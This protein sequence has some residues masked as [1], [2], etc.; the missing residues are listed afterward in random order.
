V[1][2]QSESVSRVSP[3]MSSEP[4]SDSDSLPAD[5]S[6][7][8]TQSSSAGSERDGAEARSLPFTPDF[9]A[10]LLAD[11][12]GESAE[13]VESKLIRCQQIIDYHFRDP[14]LLHAAL[15]HASCATHRLASNERL[16]FLGDS[17]LGII[18]C[19]WLYQEYPE[20]SEGDLTK[21]K[22]SVVSRRS[23]GKVACELGLD[24]CLIVGK[25]VMKSRSFP[26][27]L[28]SDVFESVVAAIFLDGGLDMVRPRLRKWLAGEVSAAVE[29]QN[30]GNY[31][32]TLQQYAQRECASTPVYKLISESG[33]DHRKRFQVAAVIN[34]EQYHPAWGNNK[35][36]A[37]QHAAANAL[38][39][40][41]REPPPFD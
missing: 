14:L 26:R 4:L 32:S 35:K 20:Y 38:A 2:Y 29:D 41:H 5:L 1:S 37:E 25:G 6:A 33:P 27:S 18:V 28:V 36:D 17:V 7:T 15:T 23:C 19:E 40:L 24:T 3:V 31:K 13:S 9:R 39:I 10:D 30:S 22:S 21:I 11:P 16:E 12:N 8:D 34:N